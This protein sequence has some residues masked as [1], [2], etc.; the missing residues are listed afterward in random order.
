MPW[1]SS[2]GIW[3]CNT[4]AQEAKQEARKALLR[5]E[6]KLHEGEIK[7]GGV[8]REVAQRRK[9]AR[10]AQIEEEEEERRTAIAFASVI[11]VT[12]TSH[13]DAVWVPA[14]EFPPE[15]RPVQQPPIS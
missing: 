5:Q 15:S 12:H 4:E 8:E 6:E 2:S 13:S 9:T 1:P 14:R 7:R 3:L 10:T 11:G